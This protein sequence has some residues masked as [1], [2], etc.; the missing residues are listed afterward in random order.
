M[1]LRVLFVQV[2]GDNLIGIFSNK[3]YAADITPPMDL[4]Y[5]EGNASGTITL[6]KLSTE[7]ADEFATSTAV[8]APDGIGHC[9]GL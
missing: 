7:L 3:V 6:D 8:S 2:S 5:R 1:P 9:G 4:Y